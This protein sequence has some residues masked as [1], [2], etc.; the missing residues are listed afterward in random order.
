M[1]ESAGARSRF[2]PGWTGRLALSVGGLAAAAAVIALMVIPREH[3][4]PDTL[5]AKGPAGPAVTLEVSC[6][7]G[8]LAACPV[9]ATLLFAA[10][11]DA[12]TQGYLAAYAQQGG[13]GERVWYFS[14]DG[15]SPELRPTGGLQPASRAVRIGAE[16]VPGPYVLH[17]FLTR[18]PLSRAALLAG[19]A[20]GDVLAS[21]DVSLTVTP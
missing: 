1:A 11:G 21:R 19:P 2:A 12:T 8:A 13:A 14:A 5:R 17:L 15:E 6:K 16:H 7:G 18:A 4:A 20:A 10:Q 9:G 3:D